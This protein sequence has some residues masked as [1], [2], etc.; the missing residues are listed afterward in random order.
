MQ[1]SLLKLLLIKKSV[2]DAIYL[3]KSVD[4]KRLQIYVGLLKEMLN[5]KK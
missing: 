4:D 3:A 5:K 1:A 2:E